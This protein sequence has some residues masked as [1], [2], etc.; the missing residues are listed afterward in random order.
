ML[1][2]KNWRKYHGQ[3]SAEDSLSGHKFEKKLYEEQHDFNLKVL[4]HLQNVASLDS[5]MGRDE[6]EAGMSLIKAWNKFLIL[7]DAFGWDVALCYA[8]EPLTE[9]SE[10][11]TKIHRAKK[12]GKIRRDERFK[13]KLKAARFYHF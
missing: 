3:R 11:E 13:T 2:W 9:D 7:A 5:S 4:R 6:I 10:D 8:K 12:E 1:D